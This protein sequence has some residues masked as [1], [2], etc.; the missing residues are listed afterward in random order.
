M[1]LRA[2]E[3]LAG[4]KDVQAAKAL[5]ELVRVSCRQYCSMTVTAVLQ[6]WQG[7]GMCQDWV[8]ELLI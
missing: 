1:M 8:P 5:A 7:I 4:K 6:L 2:G 3:F